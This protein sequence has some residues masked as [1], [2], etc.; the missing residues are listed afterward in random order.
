MKKTLTKHQA[1][2]LGE[3]KRK[4]IINIWRWGLLLALI[5]LWE[6]LANLGVI[7]AF[8]M[9]SPSR[10]IAT[11]SNLATD[12]SLF[13]H[14]GVTLYETVAGFLIATLLGTLVAI[15]FWWWNF[16]SQT[17]EPYIVVL[18]ALP[19]IALG[20]IIIIW[21]GATAKSIIAMGFLICIIVTVINILGTFIATDEGKIF[22]LR[23]MGA[24]KWQILCKLVIPH[25][26]ASIVD[27]IK[28]VIGLAWVGVIMGEYLVSGAG[29]GYL[30]IYGGQVFRIDLVMASTVI[31][32]ILAFLMYFLVVMHLHYVSFL[33]LL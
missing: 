13:Y 24:S 33:A 4:I 18:N 11:V 2:L 27:T 19:K 1:Y 25:S 26:I 12:G 9:S 5:I 15:A 8:I 10:M 7:D 22:L 28:I 31:L 17:L 3:K 23:S 6:V 21:V 32:C 14:I 30:I 16:L 29:L 20:P